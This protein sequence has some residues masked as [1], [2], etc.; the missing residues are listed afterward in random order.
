MLQKQLPQL[1]LLRQ[2]AEEPHLGALVQLCHSFLGTNRIEE[3]L[4]DVFR[5]VWFYGM[6]ELVQWTIFQRQQELPVELS[7][8]S[9]RCWP[10]LGLTSQSPSAWGR[11]QH[12]GFLSI[13]TLPKNL[14]SKGPPSDLHSLHYYISEYDTSTIQYLSCVAWLLFKK[15]NLLSHHW[16]CGFQLPLQ[17]DCGL[18]WAAC[19]TLQHRTAP[20]SVLAEMPPW[21]R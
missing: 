6:Q 14:Q 18:M 13:S 20:G 3:F 5:V 19:F 10:S 15:I 9:G 17:Q 7:N 8:F 12:E 2:L 1:Q 11:E 4:L 16:A 21:E